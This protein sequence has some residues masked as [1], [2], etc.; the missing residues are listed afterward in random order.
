MLTFEEFLK[1]ELK[2]A[3]IKD[4]RPHPKADK[5]YC[6]DVDV[7][8]VTKQLVAGIR[9]FYA[10]ESLKGKQIVVVDNLQP[11]TIRGIESQGMLLAATDEEGISVLSP[12][13]HVKEGSKVK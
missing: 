6:L 1:L 2:I 3:T 10:E 12:D 7:G 13:R 11:A 9:A 4:V 5:L 8:G